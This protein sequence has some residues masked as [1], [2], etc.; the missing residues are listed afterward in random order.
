MRCIRIGV[1]GDRCIVPAST[2][3]RSADA[4]EAARMRLGVS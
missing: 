2:R 1:L 3:F 4:G